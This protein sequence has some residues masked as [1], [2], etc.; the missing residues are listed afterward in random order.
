ML[1]LVDRHNDNHNFRIKVKTIIG[2]YGAN[3]KPKNVVG[4]NNLHMLLGFW[5]IIH[6]TT[7]LFYFLIIK[8]I[9][10]LTCICY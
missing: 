5:E 2:N 4:F 9:V 1:K 3:F 7:I 10:V 8:I 6:V